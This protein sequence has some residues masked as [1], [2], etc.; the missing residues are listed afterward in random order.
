MA[1]NNRTAK[2]S[3]RNYSG[4]LTTNTNRR[5]FQSNR[6]NTGGTDVYV[7]RIGITHKFLDFDS[8]EYHRIILEENE[9]ELILCKNNIR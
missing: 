2:V 5:S 3:L 7:S 6:L 9:M 8:I 1:R 4:T